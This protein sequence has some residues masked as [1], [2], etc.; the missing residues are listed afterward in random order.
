MNYNRAIFTQT[1]HWAIGVQG[2]KA[3]INKLVGVFGVTRQT[4]Q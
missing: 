2:L 3:K 4:S 1:I